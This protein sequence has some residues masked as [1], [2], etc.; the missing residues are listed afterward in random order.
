LQYRNIRKEVLDKIDKT[1][2][3]GD[4]IYRKDLQDFEKKIAAYSGVKYGI[5]TD[6]CTGALFIALKALGIEKGDEVITVGHTYIATIDVIIHCGAKPV[7][8]DVGN[9]YNINP[10][11]IEK[12]IT[13]RTK[14]IIPVH[15]NGR[16]C[17]MDKI[18]SIAKRYELFVVEDAA[19]ALGASYQGGK[20]GSFGDVGC[21]SFYP[22][23]VLGSYGEG[24]MA[25]TDNKELADKMYWLRDH[26]EFPGYLRKG[27]ERI[28]NGWGYN[29]IMDNLQAAILNVKFKYFEKAIKRRREIAKMYSCAN[30]QILEDESIIQ[31]PCFDKDDV[32]QNF[33][34]L[35][36]KRDELQ[37]YLEKKGI[38][39]LVSWRIPNHKQAS[40]RELHKFNK[41]PFTEQISEEALSLP[42]YPE[43]TDKQV[44]YVVNSIV[45]FY[46][47]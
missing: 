14:A 34:I 22:A 10:D 47:K 24:G 44:E 19:Q 9:D 32:F 43:L 7:L 35:S 3:A 36:G 5:A 39:T 20:A 13:N 1:L 37:K 40:L 16:M 28:I 31:L 23:K 41:L 6:S 46:G 17:Q 45:Q 25:I 2:L 38:E 30:M 8:V 26:G 12:A 15:L 42:M 4:L 29:T 11:L 27:S 18:M 33:V 21:F